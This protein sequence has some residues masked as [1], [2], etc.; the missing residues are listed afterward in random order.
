MN[1]AK[2]HKGVG[3]SK[4]WFGKNKWYSCLYQIFVMAACKNS[5]WKS[6]KVFWSEPDA[7]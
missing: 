4:A 6:Q 1:N 2:F 7:L 5:G 3:V